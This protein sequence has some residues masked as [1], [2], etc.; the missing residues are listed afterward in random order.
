MF[1]ERLLIVSI[2]VTGSVRIRPLL[3]F[4]LVEVIRMV[5]MRLSRFYI[6]YIH[7]GKMGIT[8]IS[9]I[10]IGKVSIHFQSIKHIYFETGSDVS[11]SSLLFFRTTFLQN[12]NYT[13]RLHKT[14]IR[15]SNR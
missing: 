10:I 4:Y 9:H 2:Q 11:C 12:L 8:V 3:L 13:V 14:S 6:L 1:A 5:I 7:F 15:V